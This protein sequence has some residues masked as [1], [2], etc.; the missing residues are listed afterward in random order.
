MMFL[1]KNIGLSIIFVLLFTI[2]FITVTISVYTISSIL[3]GLLNE[4]DKK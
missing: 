2:L 1:L 4:E 3:G